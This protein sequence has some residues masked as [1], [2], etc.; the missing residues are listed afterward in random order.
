MNITTHFTAAAAL[1][2][3]IALTGSAALAQQSFKTPDEAVDSLVAAA[4]AHDS[5]ALTRVLGRRAT[6]IIDS[7]DPVS[8]METRRAFFTA[9]DAK[10][11]VAVS[12]GKTATLLIGPDDW[13]FPI[14]LVEQSGSWQFDT[15]TGRR[16]ILY[17]RIGRNE[18]AAIMASL[19]YVDAQNDYAA[20]DAA[21]GG[22]GVYAQKIASS[23]GKKDGLYWATKEDEAESPLGAFVAAASR[24]GRVAAGEPFHGYYYRILTRQ[25]PKAPGGEHDYIVRG[26][27][28]GGFG[29]VAW[30][31]EYGNTGV[32]TFVVNQDGDVFQKDLGER[33]DRIAAG[34]A[35]FN[36]DQ[37][38][39]KVVDTPQR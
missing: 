28:I 30:P 15:D 8:D 4:R 29:L 12:D 22:M 20:M 21:R 38:W 17:R 26:K 24:S 1:A 32:M 7:G 31:A 23:P 36:P 13:P 33:T 27:M 18:L 10:H 39:K 35:S 6:D 3:G 9:F 25:G 37:T 19:A 16:E 34:M 2:L 5:K 11:R 14:P